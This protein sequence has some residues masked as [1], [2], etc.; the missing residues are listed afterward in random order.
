MNPE[1]KAEWIERLTN[2]EREQ[3]RSFLNNKTDGTY[4][5]LGVLCEMA[6]E[7]G[8]VTSTLHQTADP[9]DR[10]RVID[11]ADFEGFYAIMPKKVV[12]WAGLDLDEFRGIGYVEQVGLGPSECLAGMNDSGKTFEEIAKVIEEKL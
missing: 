6:E 8:V 12:E 5:C 11:V 4:C 1:I 9:D 7:A 3:G 10:D 2:G